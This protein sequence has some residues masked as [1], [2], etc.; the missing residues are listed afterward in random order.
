VI[1]ISVSDD[2]VG[3]PEKFEL[4]DSPSLGLSLVHTLVEQLEGNLEILRDR[5]TTFRVTFPMGAGE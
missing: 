4:K 5:G 1:S 3:M 2:G